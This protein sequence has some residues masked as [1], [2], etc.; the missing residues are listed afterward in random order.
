MMFRIIQHVKTELLKEVDVYNNF[1]NIG[2]MITMCEYDKF[3]CVSSRYILVRI[4][5]YYFLR[6]V[7][8]ITSLPKKGLR[9]TWHVIMIPC[10]DFQCKYT[11]QILQ[12]SCMK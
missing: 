3:V 12:Q 10:V 11:V 2:P 9:T 4:T 5:D 1:I 7:A 8:T 6:L